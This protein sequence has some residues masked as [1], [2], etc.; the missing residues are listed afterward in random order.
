MYRHARLG[1][2]FAMWLG[3]GCVT[4][5]ESE[6]ESES[7]TE[8]RDPSEQGSDSIPDA[9]PQDSGAPD[10]DVSDAEL[11]W[12]GE[13]SI[14]DEPPVGCS[15]SLTASL[16]N[17]GTET[18]TIRAVEASSAAVAPDVESLPVTLAPGEVFDLPVTVTPDTEGLFEA[19]L[20]VRSS[21]SDDMRLPIELPTRGFGTCPFL[22]SGESWSATRTWTAQVVSADIILVLDSS[23]SMSRFLT[24]VAGEFGALAT[25]IRAELPD[26][27][28]SVVT[29]EDFPVGEAGEAGDLPFRLDAGQTLA[30][31]R[32]ER[33]L[34]ELEVR[35]G[36]DLP[37]AG[38]EALYQSLTGIGFDHNCDGYNEADDVAPYLASEDDAFSGATAGQ[39]GS[40]DAG[41]EGGTGR[42]ADTL[43][44]VIF[45]T[46][47]A[48]RD[49]DYG[50]WV[51]LGCPNAA[52][53]SSTLAAFDEVGARFVG[54]A[55]TTGEYEEQLRDLAVATGSVTT[56]DGLDPAV[57][58]YDESTL[59]ED[60][61]T[62][63]VTLSTYGSLS[64]LRT[65]V[66]VAEDAGL[67]AT[68]SLDAD[69]DTARG[70]DVQLTIDVQDHGTGGP[71]FTPVEVRLLADIDGRPTVLQRERLYFQR[72]PE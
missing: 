59:A 14:P 44:V 36:G 48:L 66:V 1:I 35:N 33:T 20:V 21:A 58:R 45:G 17:T 8:T 2:L 23:G 67:T 46:D 57:I 55:V 7:E 27:T 37:E 54:V 4:Q 39:A 47:A 32:V 50:D 22:A 5:K 10:G 28:F 34:A 72:T 9:D 38:F 64:N 30:L 19:E 49:G 68:V 11:S 3:A 6:V 41:T 53:Q 71:V 26:T 70:E 51:P 43:P 31:D 13:W 63:V 29:F 42:R 52:G 16:Q 62:Q 15:F 12:V 40:F 24:G 60:V 25:A 65:D 69:T 18:L 61:S 56:E